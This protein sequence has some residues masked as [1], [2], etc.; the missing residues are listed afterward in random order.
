MFRLA[1]AFYFGLL[2]MAIAAGTGLW[3]VF[4]LTGVIG[5]IESFLEELLGYEDLEFLFTRILLIWIL[6]GLVWVA[7]TALATAF[8]AALYNRVANRLG[9][10]EITVDESD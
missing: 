10:V 7:L 9:G 5:N 8:L 3:F 6:V 1:L 2:V 4:Q